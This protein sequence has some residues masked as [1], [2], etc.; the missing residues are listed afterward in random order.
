MTHVCVSKL[1][2]IGSDNGLSPGRHQ[3]IIWTNSGVFLIRSVGTNVK[4]IS[5]EIHILSFKKTLLKISSV[6]WRPFCSGGYELSSLSNISSHPGAWLWTRFFIF[7]NMSASS[8]G[9]MKKES[10]M[11]FLRN[12][13]YSFP[14][15]GKLF[16]SISPIE[17]IY[18][19][20]MDLTKT[21]TRRDEKYL[22]FWDLVRFILEYL[23]KCIIGSTQHGKQLTHYGDVIMSAIASQITSI[24]I[25]YSTVYSDAN[26]RKHQTIGPRSLVAK[27]WEL[28]K[29]DASLYCD[30]DMVIFSSYW[31][32]PIIKYHKL[33]RRLTLL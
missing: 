22:S 18:P 9:T 10:R 27:L 30:G 28:R 19:A 21:T 23:R 31:T 20:S 3:A 16:D 24:T 5:I 2:I 29:I 25:V 8:I 6:K 32:I 33:I 17:Q 12:F 15:S 4:E 13:S 7:L 14:V 26:Q 1:T 11:L